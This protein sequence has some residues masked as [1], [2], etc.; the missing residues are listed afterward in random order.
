[1]CMS[2]E[3]RRGQGVESGIRRILYS[4]YFLGPAH[5][6]HQGQQLFWRHLYPT[7]LAAAEYLGGPRSD[8]G[9][10]Q[11]GHSLSCSRNDSS[12]ADLIRSI[13]YYSD[14]ALE[15]MQSTLLRTRYNTG[16]E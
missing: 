16:D 3:Q 4:N 9:G 2:G 12:L 7:Y 10:A 8:S 13:G 11:I 1:M 5:G 15:A 6:W 14:Q